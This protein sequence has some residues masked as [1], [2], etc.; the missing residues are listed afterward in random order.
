[1]LKFFFRKQPDPTPDL[2]YNEQSD[3]Y[4]EQILR[5][6][7]S[8]KEAESAKILEQQTKEIE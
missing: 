6:L 1:M 8:Q 5:E 2:K 7:L 3:P 4:L